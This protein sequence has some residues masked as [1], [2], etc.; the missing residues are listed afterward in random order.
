MMNTFGEETKSASW[1]LGNPTLLCHWKRS[2]TTC[3][4]Q[5]CFDGAQEMDTENRGSQQLY[6]YL[7]RAPLWRGIRDKV[8]VEMEVTRD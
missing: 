6:S 5:C 3:I 8:S 1:D 7:G 4:A 2:H